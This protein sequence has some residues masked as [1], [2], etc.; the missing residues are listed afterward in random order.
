MSLECIAGRGVGKWRVD[1][2]G[3]M[4]RLLVWTMMA[5]EAQTAE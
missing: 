3:E 4:Y 2:I 1:G 5:N